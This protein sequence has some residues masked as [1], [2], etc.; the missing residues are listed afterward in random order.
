MLLSYPLTTRYISL[1]ET[2]LEPVTP[3]SLSKISKIAVREI[4]ISRCLMYVLSPLSYSG[5][6]SRRI[7]YNL[8]GSNLLTFQTN[9][10]ILTTLKLLCASFVFGAQ[11]QIRTETVMIL[12]HVP[13]PV[14]IIGHFGAG[15]ETRTR[16]MLP[17][18]DF[19]SLVSAIPPHPLLQ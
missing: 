6:L 13:L 7:N 1:P 16:T 2:G 15:G 10:K 5:I 18:R 12:S 19:K 8:K 17:S 3:C 11:F 9:R 14:G 4:C